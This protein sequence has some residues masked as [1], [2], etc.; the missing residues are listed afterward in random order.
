MWPRTTTAR[1][2]N[3]ERFE[4]RSFRLL[5]RVKTKYRSHFP[6]SKPPRTFPYDQDNA[7]VGTRNAKRDFLAD[8]K[9]ILGDYAQSTRADW[10]YRHGI[11]P[12]EREYQEPER[13][14]DTV[15]T[16]FEK[17]G[18]SDYEKFKKPEDLEKSGR[19]EKSGRYENSKK[20][21]PVERSARLHDKLDYRCESS[22]AKNL[23][24]KFQ[25]AIVSELQKPGRRVVAFSEFCKG[26]TV[27]LV[28]AQISGGTLEKVVYHEKQGVLEVFFLCQ[29]YADSFMEVALKSG[30]F[31]VNGRS[32]AVRWSDSVEARNC[33]LKPLPNYVIAEVE[34]CKASRVVILSKSVLGKKLELGMKR[35]YPNAK[36]NFTKNFDIEMIKWDFILFGG[37]V[38]VMPVVSS[39]LSV[40]LQFTDIRSALLAMHTMKQKDSEIR[41][42]Y[43][44]WHLRY[45]K[46]PT[47][48]PCYRV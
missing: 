17:S 14:K 19:N 5:D 31:V 34:L 45:G 15:Q 38:E 40:L 20:F 46:D 1:V 30:L 29:K 35:N 13:R 37:I 25:P 12:G 26:M 16:W 4:L 11:G 39:R 43:P 36:H 27:P 3:P 41:A 22:L 21:E 10:S 23:A 28:L 32:L 18:K 8:A 7:T 6:S 2:N 44:D 48:R 47:A 9:M 24:P 42:K 33:E